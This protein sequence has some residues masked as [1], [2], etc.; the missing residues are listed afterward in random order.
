MRVVHPVRCVLAEEASW[1]GQCALLVALVVRA[2]LSAIWEI[3][4]VKATSS[5]KS[6]VEDT[7]NFC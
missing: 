3:E 1:R 4:A 6:V 5:L 2:G 7:N